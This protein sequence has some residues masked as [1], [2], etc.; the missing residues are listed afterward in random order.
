MLPKKASLIATALIATLVTSLIGACASGP[1]AN[2]TVFPFNIDTDKLAA[3]PVKTVVIP[4]VNVGPPSRNYLEAPATRIDAMVTAY[5]KENGYKVLPQREFKARWNTAVRAFGD[6]VDPTTGRVNDKTFTQILASVRD[7]YAEEGQLDAFLFTDLVEMQ[8]AFDGGLK[9]IARWD[10]VARRPSLQ[11]PGSSVS[12]NFDWSQTASMASLQ[13][14]L[15]STD[16]E[17]LFA[18]RG[19]LDATDAIDARSSTGRYIR[20]RNVLENRT[21]NQEGVELALHPL[22]PMKKYPEP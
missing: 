3:S 4:H 16:F 8:V 20:R 11:G 21:H 14:V 17:T 1:S 7:R 2:P 9:H 12:S 10:G 22:I 5:L 6:P 19:G 13:V 18:S 15:L